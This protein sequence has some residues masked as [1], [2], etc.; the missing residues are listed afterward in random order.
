[1]EIMELN[2]RL[3]DMKS[4]EDVAAIKEENRVM[5]DSFQ[6]CVHVWFFGLLS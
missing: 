1:M 3:A 2:E 6:R 5:L 4:H